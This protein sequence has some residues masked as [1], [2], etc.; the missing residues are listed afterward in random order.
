MSEPNRPIATI[1]I[2]PRKSWLLLPA[3]LRGAQLV[4]FAALTMTAHAQLVDNTSSPHTVEA[5]IRK[6]LRDQAGPGRGDA[7][8]QETSLY[9]IRRDPFRSIR[10]G[11]QLFQ[12][13][14]TRAEGQGPLAVDGVGDLESNLAIGAGLTDSCAACHGRPRGSAGFGGA[15]ATRPDSR[16]AP[17]LFGLGLKEMLADEITADLRAIRDAASAEARST[18]RFAVKELVSKGIRFGS[19]AAYPGGGFNTDNVE[20]VDA[21]LRV[22]PFFAHGG[23]FAIRSFIIGAFNDEMGLQAV[24]SDLAIASKG[25]RVTTPSGMTLDGKLD[26]INPPPT[27]PADYPVRDPDRDGVVNEI[28][29]S[30]V[31]HLEFYLMNYFKPG[32][33]EQSE[34]T[35]SGRLLLESIGC[36][37]CHIPDLRIER[38][39]RVADVETVFDPERGG[40]NRLFAVATPLYATH[41]D[42]RGYSLKTAEGG[43]F[44]VENIFTD[45]KRHDLGSA[46]HERNYD[47]EIQREFLTTPLWGIGSTSPY[48]HD[49]RSINMN[50]VI[51]R[52]GGE[53][54]TSR[55]GFAALGEADR[56]AILAFLSSLILFPPDDTA[57]N[58][59]PGDP[60]QDG[61]PQTAHGSIGLGSLFNDP[62]DIE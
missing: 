39:R 44:L 27:S 54:R 31:D 57:S 22:R 53:S 62:L 10:R 59:N 26:T 1:G 6:S 19:I 32:L 7:M 45:F 25:G 36:T 16:D 60:S 23:T 8:T 46:F 42:G 38:D 51:L 52:H 40:F 28:T 3:G 37:S 33:Y 9:I 21:D 12:R 4:A 58:L 20:G 11:R 14:F 30:I 24:D 50:E 29:E 5:G 15:V 61:Y 56:Q 49:G 43:A 34:T 48:G 2:S 41:S 18:G 17:H 47:G 35:A 13:K 55:D